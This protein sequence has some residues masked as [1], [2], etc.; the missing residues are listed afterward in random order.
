MRRGQPLPVA[1]VP[2]PA[3]SLPPPLSVPNRLRRKGSASVHFMEVLH[4]LAGLVAGAE[5]PAEEEMRMHGYMAPQLPKVGGVPS[6]AEAIR[7]FLVQ[8]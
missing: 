7:C 6:A 8:G 1:A 4:A 5:L 2:A 3:P